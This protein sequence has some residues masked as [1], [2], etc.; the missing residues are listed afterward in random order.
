LFRYKLEAINKKRFSDRRCLVGRCLCSGD[1]KFELYFFG[2]GKVRAFESGGHDGEEAS[3]LLSHDEIEEVPIRIDGNMDAVAKPEQGEEGGGFIVTGS[4][5]CVTKPP[6]VPM[7]PDDR[8]RDEERDEE[9]QGS[10][11]DDD[12]DDSRLSS[13][14]VE[15]KEGGGTKS[16][17]PEPARAAAAER[18]RTTTASSAGAD[19]CP[20]RVGH[21]SDDA[22]LTVAAVA[23]AASFRSPARR[24]RSGAG[25]P[26]DP[27]T[28]TII[29][30]AAELRRN[31]NLAVGR[32]IARHFV[33]PSDAS[34][35]KLYHGTIVASSRRTSM[36]DD[37]KAKLTRA[38][39]TRE[40]IFWDV[41]YDDGDAE[42]L[43]ADQVVG[44]LKLYRAFPKP[45]PLDGQPSGAGIEPLS[46]RRQR[47][48]KR[49]AMGISPTPHLPRPAVLQVYESLFGRSDAV[50]AGSVGPF[51]P[52]PNLKEEVVR[53]VEERAD[54]E[55][56]SIEAE[57]KDKAGRGIE[58]IERAKA[59]LIQLHV[60]DGCGV[61]ELERAKEALQLGVRREK[62]KRLADV[63]ADVTR[64]TR[65]LN[66]WGRGSTLTT[67][68]PMVLRSLASGR[69]DPSRPH[70][71]SSA[72]QA[73]ADQI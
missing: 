42:S 21:Q 47:G 29:P 51:A 7:V 65:V 22:G 2:P 46:S 60:R 13:W 16:A 31:P 36:T 43:D 34:K 1:Y 52:S 64:K 44:V 23:D 3:P 62:R 33:D 59:V 4:T 66:E 38:T 67:T 41:T 14:Y 69:A 25:P 26:V 61:E 28:I 9:C 35:V 58:A 63:D 17:A 12:D 32:G 56:T 5:S 27:A 71:A 19:E 8:R 48:S 40:R 57:T 11:G 15:R 20:L 70:N 24:S 30:T 49:S 50:A 10:G 53:Y 45:N 6:H 18:G 54:A 55:R 37:K 68:S 39:G 72:T 73:A